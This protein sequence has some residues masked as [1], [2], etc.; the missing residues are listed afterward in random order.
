MFF[1]DVLGVFRFRSGQIVCMKKG[2][3]LAPN[4]MNMLDTLLQILS[5]LAP[6]QCL[7][8]MLKQHILALLRRTDFAS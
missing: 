8:T 5:P 1:R 6:V 2:F 4:G 7:L 3:V